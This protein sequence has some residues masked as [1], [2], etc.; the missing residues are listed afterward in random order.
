MEK[1]EVG[2]TWLLSSPARTGAGRDDGLTKGNDR[3][4]ERKKRRFD[5][6]SRTINKERIITT[7]KRRKKVKDG[8]YCRRHHVS[9]S[10]FPEKTECQR[11]P[12]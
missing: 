4:R 12:W 3:K 6:S 11:V 9:H 5:C 8:C 7:E 1:E 2:G 10:T